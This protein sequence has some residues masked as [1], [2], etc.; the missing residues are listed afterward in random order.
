MRV[1]HVGCAVVYE[2]GVETALVDVVADGW[3]EV[4]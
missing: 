4:G 2:F 1:G 3:R